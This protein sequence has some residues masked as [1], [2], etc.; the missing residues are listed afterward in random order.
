MHFFYNCKICIHFEVT[1]P[2]WHFSFF[3]GIYKYNLN[4][5]NKLSRTEVGNS[6]YVA[7]IFLQSHLW[8]SVIIQKNVEGSSF[9]KPISNQS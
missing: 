1:W 5:W 7:G 6:A 8:F 3:R 9:V 2:F 4:H